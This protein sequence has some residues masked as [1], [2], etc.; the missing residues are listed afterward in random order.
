MPYVPTI[1]GIIDDIERMLEVMDEH[2]SGTWFDGRGALEA[3]DRKVRELLGSYRRDDHMPEEVEI[4]F[5]GL[6][7]GDPKL[8]NVWAAAGYLSILKP[9]WATLDRLDRV[10]Y[11]RRLDSE[12]TAAK[13]LAEA[14]VNLV[15]PAFEEALKACAD[16]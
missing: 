4:E 7:H 14:R 12:E 1:S 3:Y 10:A 9:H 11:E 6:L 15:R 16:V 5:Y 13:E 8:R 2:L